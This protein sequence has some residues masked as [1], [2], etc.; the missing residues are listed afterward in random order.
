MLVLYKLFSAEIIRKMIILEIFQ[1]VV[2]TMRA[3]LC[4]SDDEGVQERHGLVE[5]FFDRFGP[6]LNLGALIVILA[7]SNKNMAAAIW[8][9]FGIEAFL[10]LADMYRSRYNKNVAFPDIVRSALLLSYTLCIIFY[11][12]FTPP[13]GSQYVG[14]VVLTT[15]T[16]AMIASLVFMYPFTL[17]YSSPKVDEPVRRSTGFFRLNQILT[18]FWCCIMGIATGCT[19]GSLRYPNDST[20]Q[21]VLGIVM[22]IVMPIVGQVLTPLLV[23]CLKSFSS[24]SLRK[25]DEEMKKGSDLGYEEHEPLLEQV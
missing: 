5:E 25:R 6:I 13:L 8:V 17:Q 10:M 24:R 9:A 4:G 22:P 15:V 23:S 3:T 21:I 16:G 1:H 18:L 19:W 7:V 20:A 11:Y 2:S 14:V 12:V